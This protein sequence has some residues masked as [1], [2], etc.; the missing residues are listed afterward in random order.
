MYFFAVAESFDAATGETVALGV[1]EI[2]GV[3]FAFGFKLFAAALTAFTEFTLSKATEVGA[4]VAEAFGSGCA[5]DID[6]V[7]G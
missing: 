6:A 1:A 3:N 2:A 7:F 5:F 4:A